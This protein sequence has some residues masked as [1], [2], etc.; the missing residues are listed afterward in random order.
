M[1]L[2]I[3]CILEREDLNTPYMEGRS[4]LTAY[5]GESL[6]GCCEEES[7]ALDNIIQVNFGTSHSTSEAARHSGDALL[8]PLDEFLSHGPNLR[9]H[10]APKGLAAVRSI[11]NKIRDG[12]A[13]VPLPPDLSS[14]CDER[15]FNTAVIFDLEQL[16]LILEHALKRHTRFCLTFEV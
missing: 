5:C 8:S 16:E 3:K 2:A 10:E 1:G 13:M 7:H 15:E 4:L 12:G 9:W 11:L 6:D 14:C